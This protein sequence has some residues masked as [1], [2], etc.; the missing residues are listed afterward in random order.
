[1]DTQKQGVM[2]YQT[3][4]SIIICGWDFPFSV[5]CLN[6]QVFCVFRHQGQF[7][8]VFEEEL[9][10]IA[11]AKMNTL[12]QGVLQTHLVKHN[13]RV[14]FLVFS[15]RR[16]KPLTNSHLQKTSPCQNL[17]DQLSSLNS[18]TRTTTP[19]LAPSSIKV[20]QACSTLQGYVHATHYTVILV[21][22]ERFDCRRH[23]G[24]H[25]QYVVSLC[26]GG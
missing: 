7:D 1:M 22:W 5:G 6:I 21:W 18:P 25:A 15:L 4:V 23:P 26:E 16:F 11:F 17:P 13:L 12:K 19:V 8:I 20:E 24:G 3:T 14:R 10:Q 9:L 2:T